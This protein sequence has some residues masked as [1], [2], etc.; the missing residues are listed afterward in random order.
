MGSTYL[1][2]GVGFRAW[3]SSEDAT[4]TANEKKRTTRKEFFMKLTGIRRSTEKWSPM[5]EE[6][7][8]RRI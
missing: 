8:D 4:A 5:N 6:L 7:K 1:F 2:D 3:T